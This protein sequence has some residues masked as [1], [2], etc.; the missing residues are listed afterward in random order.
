MNGAKFQK[1]IFSVLVFLYFL[2]LA[3]GCS[4]L[5]NLTFQKERLQ[6][7]HDSGKY[8]ADI[9]SVID[10]ATVHVKNRAASGEQNLAIVLDID[11][12][13]LTDWDYILAYDFGWDKK[14][15]SD[16]I[17]RA[18]AKPIQPT[19]QFYC[20]AKKLGIKVFFITGRTQDFEQATVKNLN[21]AG[22]ENFDGVFLKP[23]TDHSPSVSTFKTS[24]RRRL[25]DQ[26]LKIIANIGDQDSDLKGGF[27]ECA[28]KLPDPFYYS[29]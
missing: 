13:S 1:L 10:R 19:L 7:Y 12:T 28:F 18:N 21:A 24:T 8:E 2:A 6:K 29:P 22:Y 26:G 11:E 5:P 15:F 23:V 17:E 4:S 9:Q 3:S 16:W 14:S 25:S 20:F 27:A